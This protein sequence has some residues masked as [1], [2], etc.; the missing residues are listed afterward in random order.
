MGCILLL[1]HPAPLTGTATLEG[2][3]FI[4]LI[5]KA[6]ATR[7]PHGDDNKKSNV[8]FINACNTLS[9]LHEDSERQKS[10]M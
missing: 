7:T 9:I 2:Q 10:G 6:D 3:L 5:L 4:V 8:V 1:M